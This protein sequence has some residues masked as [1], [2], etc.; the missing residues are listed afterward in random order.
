M[1]GGNGLIYTQVVS[2]QRGKDHINAKDNLKADN[3]KVDNLK[4]DNLKADNL[5]V[6]EYKN[7]LYVS[8]YDLVNMKIF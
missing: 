3:L 6:E 7:I 1:G 5:I 4:V 8:Q 2:G